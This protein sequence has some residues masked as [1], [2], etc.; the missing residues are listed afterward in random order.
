MSNVLL[1]GCEAGEVRLV[2]GSSSREGRLE[3]CNANVWGTVCDDSFSATDATVVC[4]QLGF[5]ETG[6]QLQNL[7]AIVHFESLNFIHVF[8]IPT[9]NTKYMHTSNCH[10]LKE[11]LLIFIQY[12]PLHAD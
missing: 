12:L 5:S 3:I 6:T 11:S 8:L 2:N 7:T 4:R 10:C 9:K 1:A